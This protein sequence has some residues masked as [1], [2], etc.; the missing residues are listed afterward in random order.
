MFDYGISRRL[1]DG[2]PLYSEASEV[3]ADRKAWRRV[4]YQLVDDRPSF[5]DDTMDFRP[6]MK[7]TNAN[8]CVLRF[9]SVHPSAK[10][11]VKHF[12]L[13]QIDQGIKIP[14]QYS[15][16]GRMSKLINAAVRNNAAHSFDALLTDDV[17]EALEAVWPDSLGMRKVVL[18]DMIHF[19]DFLRL[20]MNFY[21]AVDNETLYE[22]YEFLKDSLSGY[23][24]SRHSV[25]LPEEVL[26]PIMKGFNDVMRDESKP[27][28]MRMTAGM[29]L[30]D[31]Q[32]GLRTAEIPALEVDCLKQVECFDGKVHDY[33]EYNAM[34][35]APAFVEAIKQRTI[36]TPLA[37][38]T[39][40]YL[41]ELRKR[42]PGHEKNPFLFIANEKCADGRVYNKEMFRLM[43]RKLCATALEHLFVNPILNIGQT[44]VYSTHVT[45]KDS[46]HVTY[47]ALYIPNIYCFRVT[48]ATTLY[49]K[50]MS[51]DA[52]N[53]MMS[54][55]PGTSDVPYI[56]D[57]EPGPEAYLG[58][59]ELFENV[60]YPHGLTEVFENINTEA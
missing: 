6:N 40:E 15:R 28:Q 34:K 43:Y 16:L 38:E 24:G 27:L 3:L 18:S 20:E 45:G 36:C 46:W 31:T 32:L 35:P 23:G 30:A 57:V 8:A 19:I 21:M 58:L 4:V 60:T 9:G 55:T 49:R 39:I 12:I 44:K 29:M 48:F 1:V 51:P 13:D 41:L 50:G 5:E 42:I 14:T 17:L 56:R 10:V 2:I 25:F 59:D 11:Y 26:A 53:A 33:V 54:H 52:I 7:Y 37:K 47:K 22:H